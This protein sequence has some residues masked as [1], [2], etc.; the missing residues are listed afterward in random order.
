MIVNYSI[1]VK[2]VDYYSI[3]KVNKAATKDEIKK[4]YK[5]LARKW[6][7]DKN[8]DN[9]EEATKKFK[10]V[11]EAYQILSDDSKRRIY[12]RDGKEGLFP[13]SQ[14]KSSS[15]RSRNKEQS[16]RRPSQDENWSGFTDFTQRDEEEFPSA[17]RRR[18]Q[19]RSHRN[20]TS[21]PDLF[22]S[23]FGHSFMFKDPDTLFKDF[24][25]GKDPFED[26]H[27]VHHREI[28]P[29]QSLFFS[30][31]FSVPS[32]G[33]RRP[34]LLPDIASGHHSSMFQDFED[35]DRLFSGFGS[36]L[37]GGGSRSSGNRRHRH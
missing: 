14:P 4:A 8:P 34:I 20:S 25:G 13:G 24:F 29:D 33:R 36:I 21:T 1:G 7:P 16:Y 6:H 19:F 22:S 11:S 23:S 32:G 9:Q 26:F 30:S 12:D 5:E 10:Q 15:R 18:N 28:R 31:S 17:G 27:S 2:M 3:L 35:M 37:L